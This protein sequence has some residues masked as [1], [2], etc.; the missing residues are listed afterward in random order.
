ML[1]HMNRNVT[2]R[3]TVEFIDMQDISA[4]AKDF[5][6]YLASEGP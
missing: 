1:T 6:Q 5:V 3:N 2:V 4:F